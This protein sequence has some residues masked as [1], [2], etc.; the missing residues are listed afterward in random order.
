MITK[1]SIELY[2]LKFS[3]T[4]PPPPNI[5]KNFFQILENL[6]FYISV[7]KLLA[8]SIIQILHYLWSQY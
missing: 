4:F 2:H 6:M 7:V 8:L 5:Q 1:T 3:L